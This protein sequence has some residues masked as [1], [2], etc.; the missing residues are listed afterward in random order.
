MSGRRLAH[1][2]P[3]MAWLAGGIALSLGLA[4]RIRGA[5]GDLWLDEI[6]SLR[7]VALLREGRFLVESLAVDNN[8]YLNTLF[9][10][11]VGPDAPAPVLRSFSILLGLA[12]VPVAG[13]AMRRIGLSGMIAGMTVFAA[14]YLFVN[15]GSEARG[16][17]GLILMTLL[18]LVL[19]ERGLEKPERATATALG[20]VAVAGFLFQPIMV[21][22]L[23]LLG[24]WAL[25][26][27]WRASGDVKR[28]VQATWR[29]FMPALAG[30]LPI[31]VLIGGAVFRSGT[32]LIAAK[33][34]FSPANLLQGYAGLFR[35]LLGIPDAVPDLLVLAV[36]L[37]T[38]IAVGMVLRSTR[39][40]LG[41]IALILFPL[42]VL[43]VQPPNVQFPRYY[44]ASGVV[45]LLLLAELFAAAWQRG[46]A[47]RVVAGVLAIA[48]AFGN[49]SEIVKL[50]R[51]GR[52][53]PLPAMRQIA[54]ADQ[55]VL[56]NVRDQVVVAYLGR[57]HGI[58]VTTV[59]PAELCRKRPA[60]MLTSDEGA[61][62]RLTFTQPGCTAAFR[63]ES[64]TPFWGLSGSSWT[65]YR[66]E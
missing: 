66:A 43:V 31:V 38:L 56:L 54:A 26:A 10:L 14:A 48:I 11:L 28:S 18:A 15:Y 20:I 65:L 2:V 42:M 46:L 25:W 5:E 12:A 37:V 3:A 64:A 27:S 1:R 53:D 4:L 59:E 39:T 63:R 47:W 45:F 57:R 35:A 23:G 6:W 61:P 50:F 58:G 8:H 52:G 34:P 7:L 29:L 22:S 51:Y 17:A 32:Y 13:T 19:V 49:A 21:L 9:L 62:E 36:P 24:L 33:T 60:F 40:S 41:I 55:A 44:L 30:L 16:Y